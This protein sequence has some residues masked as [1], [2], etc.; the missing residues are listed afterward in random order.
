MLALGVGLRV[1]PYDDFDETAELQVVL[2]PATG[3]GGYELVDVPG[4]APWSMLR[5]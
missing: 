2:A 3:D 5:G 4:D 1:R